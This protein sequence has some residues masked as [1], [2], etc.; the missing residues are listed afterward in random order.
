MHLSHAPQIASLRENLLCTVRRHPER[1]AVTYAMDKQSPRIGCQWHTLTWHEFALLLAEVAA[2]LDELCDPGSTVAVLAATDARYPILEQAMIVTGRRFQ[3]LYTSTADDELVRAMNVTS[4]S[5]L[6]VGDDQWERVQRGSLAA[7]LRG[8]VKVVELSTVVRLPNTGGRRGGLLAADTE[9]FDT[10]QVRASLARWPERCGADAVLYLQ[11]TGTSGPANVI[12]ISQTAILAAMDALP[13]EV[14]KPHPVLL[15]FLPTAHISERLLIGYLSVVLGGHMWFGG[16]TTTLGADL[17]HC[18][19]T[20]FLAPPLVL[21]AIRSEATAAAS[22]SLLGRHLLRSAAADA[23]R[24]GSQSLTG[25][26]KRRLQSRFFGWLVRRKSGLGRA[27]IAIAGTAPLAPDLHAWWET[28]GLRLRD[29]Y[30]QTEVS[31]ATSMTR[32]AGSIRGGV[33]RPL[34]GVEVKVAD[35]GELLVRS[36]SI[37]TR[38]VGDEQRTAEAFESGWFKTG[39]R[40]RLTDN[41]DLVLLGRIQ[42]MI[43]TPGGGV[44]DLTDLTRRITSALG[45]ADVAY[46]RDESGVYLYVAVHPE[47]IPRHVLIVEGILDPIRASDPVAEVLQSQLQTFPGRNA[48]VGFALFR[49]GFGSRDGEVGPTGKP[50]GWRIHQL[51]STHVRRP[52]WRSNLATITDPQ[53]TLAS[54]ITDVMDLSVGA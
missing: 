1:P 37:F 7:D 50:R 4:A 14:L 13:E 42:S 15:S 12:E 54:A 38:Y 53:R 36:P 25:P 22:T 2:G 18:K 39:D 24:I 46:F 44:A 11:T 16:G 47:G 51:R 52:S 5:V 9:P 30:G 6:V 17:L 26:K 8:S 40:A 41:G 19:P 23:D 10:D 28:L 43:P 21:E 3:P 29:V 45:A 27:D 35:H 32:P 34:P 20:V 33:G 48:I 31:G 49:G